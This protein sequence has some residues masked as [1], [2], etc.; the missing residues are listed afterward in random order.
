MP[1]RNAT[2]G[3]FIATKTTGIYKRNDASGKP[4]KTF[5]VRYKKSDGKRTYEAVGSFE[6]AKSR[7]ADVQNKGFKGELIGSTT[8]TVGDIL[9]GWHAMREVTVKP[10]TRFSERLN[11]RLYIEPEWATKRLMQISTNAITTWVNGL[12][13]QDGSG[14]LS[15]GTRRLILTMLTSILDYAV[16]EWFI[17]GKPGRSLPRKAKPT[18]KPYDYKVLS[19]DQLDR[20]LASVSKGRQWL[21]LCDLVDRAH[22]TPARRGRRS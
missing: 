6:A 4:G 9:P 1:E 8:T 11:T 14:P 13:K 10:Q 12:M 5:Y 7:L 15:D 3:A 2:P 19:A 18:P 21:K 17:S 20:L 16:A 22:R